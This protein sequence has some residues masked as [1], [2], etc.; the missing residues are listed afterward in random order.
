ML[1]SIYLLMGGQN[2]KVQSSQQI[3][4]VTDWEVKSLAD[5][6]FV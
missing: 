4:S 6:L 3:I 5:F 2:A 1:V